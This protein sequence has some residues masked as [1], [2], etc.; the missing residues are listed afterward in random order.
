VLNVVTV[1]M[2]MQMGTDSGAG[3]GA[4]DHTVWGVIYD[5]VTPALY[6]RSETNQ[7]LQ[8][9]VLADIPLSPGSKSKKLLLETNSLPWFNDASGALK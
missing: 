7:N 9:V 8:Q 4:G 1:P 6:W 2:G 3:E 5:H